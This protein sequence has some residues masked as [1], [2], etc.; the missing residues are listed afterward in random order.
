MNLADTP[1]Q[2]WAAPDVP[3]VPAVPGRLLLATREGTLEPVVA[4]DGV[5]GMYVCGITPYDATHLGHA[6]TYVTFDLANRVLRDSGVQVRY[7]QNVTDVDDPLLERAARDGVDW[8]D[9]AHSEIELFKDDMSALRVLP[10]QVYASVVQ[11]MDR[12]IAVVT[13]LLDSGA[14]YAVETDLYLDLSVQDSFGSVSG[15]N[16]EEM[17]AVFADRGGDPEREGKR[18]PLDPLL[19]RG[20]RPGEPAW[21]GGV[22]GRG[23]PGWHVECTTIAL[24]NLGMGFALQA[25]GTDL[26]FPHHEMSA[27]QAVAL[28]GTPP[29]AH[30][31]AYQAMVGFEGHKMSKSRGN[32][33]R[34]AQL[35]RDG[36]D[37]MAIRLML[38]DQHYRTEWEYT[39]DLLAA[40]Q[41]RLDRWRVA[42]SGGDDRDADDLLVTVRAA[43]RADLDAPSALRAVD[44]WAGRVPSGGQPSVAV[45][46]LIDALL[47]VALS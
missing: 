13:K 46:D 24:D 32:L 10:P 11:T 38:L 6:A 12:H 42:T 5:A 26:I 19:W 25:G 20:E 18:D 3:A 43:L 41:A 23:R 27:V 22:L 1:L 7:V 21:D 4:T 37:P 29:F 9:L 34:V 30:S 2:P 33:V 31:F 17:M 45:R 15:W 8:Q 14:A 39:D 40:A 44:R 47:G 36:V 35:R 28:T 16:R